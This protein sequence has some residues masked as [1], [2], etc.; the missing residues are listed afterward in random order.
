MVQEGRVSFG[1]VEFVDIGL[2]LSDV[3]VEEF[4]DGVSGFSGF[5]ELL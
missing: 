3:L 4:G 1:V 5:E 2:E